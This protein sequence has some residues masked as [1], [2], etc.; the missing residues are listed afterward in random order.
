MAVVRNVTVRVAGDITDLQKKMLDAQKTM[1]KLGK[2]LTNIGKNLTAGI[3]LP[4]TA[5]GVASVKTAADFEKAMSEVSAITGSTGKEFETLESLAKEMGA[6]TSKSASQA[7][8][9]IR[10][11][12]LAG[13][14]TTQ[15]MEG[16]EPILRLSEAGNLDLGRASDLV[17]DAMSAM[18]LTTAE[19]SGYLDQVSQTSR[20]SNTNIDSLMEAF[21]VAGGTLKNLNVPLDEANALLGVLAN[22]GMKGSEA[23]NSLN[24]ILINLT[25]GAGQAGVAMDELGLSAFDSEG[26]FKGV[27]QTLLE[28]QE[29]LSGMTEEQKNTYLAMIGGKTQI[30]TLNNLLSGTSEEFSELR[31]NVNESDGALMEM[32]TV[33]Q[34]N[35]NGQLTQLKSALEGVA[36]EIGNILIP[37]VKNLVDNH[38]KPAVDWFAQL[39]ENTKKNIVVVGGLAAAIGP[40]L[41]VMG[42]LFKSIGLIIGGIKS[43]I[44]VTTSLV[45]WVKTLNFAWVTKTA[46]VVAS[47]A[48]L[49]AN[50]VATIATTVATK[51]MTAAQWLLNAALTANPIG[52]VI[53]LFAALAAG[54]VY[55]WN[56]NEGFRNALIS[57]WDGIKSAA[58][59]LGEM[60][61]NVWKGINDTIKN[62]IN[63][64]IGRINKFINGINGIRITVPSVDIPLI[65]EVGGFSIGLPQIPNIPQ[66]ATGTNYVP[67]DMLAFIH[68]GE[69]VVPKKYNDNNRNITI[70]LDG[71][72][73]YE[74]IDSYLGNRMLGLGGV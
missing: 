15:I 22:R 41:I 49:I 37:V 44:L 35:L 1:E 5:M 36:I 45:K 32:A 60:I 17:T 34:D 74:G 18:G 8:D 46:S 73:I 13:W 55:L 19:L 63:G 7:A 70:Y 23:G 56:T 57:A 31:E 54:I 62:S 6:S 48:S 68:E 38:I 65:G 9:A 71:K 58:K 33:M 39:D 72:K 52:I 26:N 10:F 21:I 25:S 43:T 59:S 53:A 51:A 40:L 24:S 12:G 29:K 11:M 14:N 42:T 20:S 30:T 16:L 64:I 2:K 67:Q 69:A 61:S 4:I 28:L 50:K 3:T 27:S 66:L 47:T